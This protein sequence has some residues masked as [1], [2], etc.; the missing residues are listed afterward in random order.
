[1]RSRSTRPSAPRPHWM[2]HV[3][4]F[5]AFMRRKFVTYI[6]TMREKKQK[7]PS[8]NSTPHPD[9]AA[10]VHTARRIRLDADMTAGNALHSIVDNCLE[11]IH[12]NKTGVT[13]GNNPESVH[14]MRVGLRRLRSAFA[15]FGKRSKPPSHLQEELDWLT[16]QLGAARDWEV[17]AGTMLPLI[18]AHAPPD[19][20][21]TSM[22]HAAENLVRDKHMQAASAVGSK[23]FTALMHDLDAWSRHA[24]PD[25]ADTALSD[26]A[27]RSLARLHKRLL[28]RGRRLKEASDEAR[29]RTRIAAKKARYAAEFFESLFP[30]RTVTRY[31]DA[32]SA[33][34]D[35]LGLL[36]DMRV[37]DRLLA[38]LGNNRHDLA[39]AIGYARGYIAATAARGQRRLAKRRKRITKIRLPM[40][41]Q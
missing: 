10:A 20:G 3:I 7:A 16:Q 12:G 5:M 31:L 28:R 11:Q 32:L 26:F 9:P 34:Q 30:K 6:Y 37:A 29:H 35:E 8:M 38:E 18:V 41:R 14:Q 36:N 27:G 19:I 1:M 17:F 23:R 24:R 4:N 39:A 33:L 15:L 21:A 22:Q 2:F 25:E 40:R 13:R